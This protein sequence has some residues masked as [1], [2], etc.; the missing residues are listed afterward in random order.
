MSFFR[1]SFKQNV[2]PKVKPVLAP[3][4]VVTT[5]V[6]HSLLRH[7]TDRSIRSVLEQSLR[8]MVAYYVDCKATG[9]V[10]ISIPNPFVLQVKARIK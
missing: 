2:L 1:T 4:E 6:A 8:Y 10:G 5:R 7:V 3:K 9:V